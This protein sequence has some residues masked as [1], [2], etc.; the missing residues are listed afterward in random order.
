[1]HALTFE[2]GALRVL[3]KSLFIS[4]GQLLVKDRFTPPQL[5]KYM[6]AW[7]DSAFDGTVEYIG[8]KPRRELFYR[9][10]TIF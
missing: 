5:P 2:I 4:I 3:K 9:I 10:P 1:M 6:F 7:P 8:V